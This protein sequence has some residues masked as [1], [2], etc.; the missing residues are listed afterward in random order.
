[1]VLEVNNTFD[2]RRPYFVERDFEEESKHLADKKLA[3]P[4]RAK[5]KRSFAKDFHVSPFS[6]R[7]GG[8]S[9]LAR[10]P[11]G[12]EM[13]GFRGIDVT[14]NLASSKGHPKLV[15]RLF[16][17]SEAVDPANM[18]LWKKTSFLSA[19][20]W[21]GFVTFPRIVKEAAVSLFEETPSRLVSTGA[22]ERE[23]WKTRG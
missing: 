8:Y 11:L 13:E 15:A 22:S 2:E 19:W 18:S 3:E 7:K 4:P 14:I 1:M 21:V 10:D 16:S 17:E 23:F 9:L 12:P 20:F 5:V 6:S